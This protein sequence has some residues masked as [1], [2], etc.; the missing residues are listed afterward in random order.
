MLMNFKQITLVGLLLTA[1][2]GYAA[3]VELKD[4][5]IVDGDVVRENPAMIWMNINGETY[6]LSRSN[7]LWYSSDRMDHHLLRNIEPNTPLSRREVAHIS[8]TVNQ[9]FQIEIR[10]PILP[11]QNR[12]VAVVP[13]PETRVAVVVPAPR[14]EIVVPAPKVDPEPVN[15]NYVPPATPGVRTST[16]ALPTLPRMTSGLIPVT[17]VNV[18]RT[19]ADLNVLRR[20]IPQLSDAADASDRREAIEALRAAGD[21]G[22]T[23]LV[24]DGLYNTIP[25]VRTESVELLATMGGTRVLKPLIEAFFSTANSTIPPYQVEY[26]NMLTGQISRLTGQD[27]YFYARRTARAPEIAGQMVAWWNINMDRFPQ[28]G[29]TPIE[30]TAPNFAQTVRQARTLVLIHRDFGGANLP[31]EVAAPPQVNSPDAQALI[32][33]VNGIPRASDNSFTDRVNPAQEPSVP[34]I[35]DDAL[36][37]PGKWREEQQTERRKEMEA[38]R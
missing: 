4:G 8:G 19:E 24:Q 10:T 18:R 1:A 6:E 17:D 27:F 33:T 21:V 9:P 34:K 11:T 29:E 2:S 23:M 38:A 22:L 28:L 15:T 7:V 5:K 20:A 30:P 14:E 31:H 13:A 3:T 26:V 35:P 37:A 25:S 36:S 12:P 32:N 16:E